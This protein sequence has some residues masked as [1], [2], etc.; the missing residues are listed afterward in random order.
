MDTSLST[1]SPTCAALGLLPQLVFVDRHAV[2]REAQGT[3]HRVRCVLEDRSAS[4]CQ[5]RS[6]SK[7]RVESMLGSSER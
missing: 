3:L 2:V 4:V 1:C 6:T 7:R 5:D